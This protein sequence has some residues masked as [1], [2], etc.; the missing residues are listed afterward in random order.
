LAQILVTGAAIAY[1]GGLVLFWLHAVLR[2]EA[3]PAVSYPKHWLLDSTLAF[4]VLTPLAAWSL[5][6]SRHAI[7]S[8][9]LSA[10]MAGALVGLA[11][12]P[13]PVVHDLV[14]GGGTVGA[15]LAAR[16]LGTDPG[17]VHHHGVEGSIAVEC[18]LQLLVALPT[19][20]WLAYLSHRVTL[21]LR[22]SALE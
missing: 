6:W 1:A 7:E 9:A 13:G 21:R 14:V 12:T 22:P 10:L 17:L 16:V 18:L 5:R 4:L 2:G 20:A 8:A 11:S 15:D 19:Y 3:G